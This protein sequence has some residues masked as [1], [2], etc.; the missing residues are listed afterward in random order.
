MLDELKLKTMAIRSWR[1]G[2][3]ET[4]VK[5]MAKGTLANP[6]YPIGFCTK[7]KYIAAR[8]PS[9]IEEIV[10][11]RRD[12]KL[13]HGAEIFVVDPLPKE[14]EFTLC[15]YSQTPA[16][17]STS[18]KDYVAHPLYPPG[19]GAPQWDL[20]YYDQSHLIHIL[21]LEPGVKLRYMSASLPTP[22]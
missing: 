19:E 6:R 9:E 20:C 5:V 2:G 4:L 18:H 16:G 7:F 22:R 8:T 17:M 11:F 3:M 14:H 21:T 1:E 15:G 10:G 13:V 12:S